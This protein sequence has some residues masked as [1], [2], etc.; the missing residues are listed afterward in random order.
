ML[1]NSQS[2]RIKPLRKVIF[3]D[4]IHHMEKARI[5]QVLLPIAFERPKIICVAQLAA[6]LLED[7]QVA[8]AGVATKLAL[9]VPEQ[10][11]LKAVIVEQRV[12]HIEEKHQFPD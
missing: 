11:A 8:C 6:K 12:V 1:Q 3:D 10:V 4:P 7:L 9:N 5:V 2:S